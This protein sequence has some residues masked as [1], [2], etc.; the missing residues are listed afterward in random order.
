MQRQRLLWA[1]KPRLCEDLARIVAIVREGLA[2]P[3]DW[4]LV[5]EAIRG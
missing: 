4:A 5:R 2:R 1:E 3:E